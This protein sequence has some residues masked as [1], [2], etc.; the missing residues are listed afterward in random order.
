MADSQPW[1]DFADGIIAENSFLAVLC[2][3]T[4]SNSGTLTIP[5]G[6]DTPTESSRLTV[7]VFE[8]MSKEVTK[9]GDTYYV[10]VF[11]MQAGAKPVSGD[12]IILHEGEPNETRLTIDEAMPTAPF[13]DAIYYEVHAR[14]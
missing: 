2:K 10:R 12:Q 1:I 14:A 9:G 5:D 4:V 3:V 8:D 11:Y 13:G 6:F 7:R